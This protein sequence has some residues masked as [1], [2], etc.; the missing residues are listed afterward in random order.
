MRNF[1]LGLACVSSAVAILLSPVAAAE[2]ASGRCAQPGQ[3]GPNEAGTSYLRCT[4]DGWI[5]V[6]R[7]VCVDFPGL[8]D[9]AGNPIREGPKYV[10]P[11]QG[12]FRVN[13]DVQPGTYRTSGSSQAGNTCSWSLQRR[14]GFASDQ[15]DGPTTVVIG[16][17]DVVFATSGCQPWIPLY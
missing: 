1:A 17:N 11:S 7:P 6:N 10:I 4:T 3:I 8:F 14:P 13:I 5:T 12:T 9:C 15:S 2:P 16:P